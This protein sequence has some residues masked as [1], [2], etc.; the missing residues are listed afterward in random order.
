MPAKKA[1]QEKF[2]R[3]LMTLCN[4]HGVYPNCN[5]EPVSLGVDEDSGDYFTFRISSTEEEG[6]ELVVRRHT[7]KKMQTVMGEVSTTDVTV[8]TFE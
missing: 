1:A 3:A 5:G 4:K 6:K 2:A 7:L 8:L